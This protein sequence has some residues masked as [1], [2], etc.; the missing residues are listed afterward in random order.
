MLPFIRD[1]RLSKTYVKSG[2]KLSIRKECHERPPRIWYV[3]SFQL[4]A[5]GIAQRL[6][7]ENI[8]NFP[9]SDK[10]GSLLSSNLY[11][12]HVLET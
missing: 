2:T 5:F 12:K 11:P 7:L 9:E 3:G 4:F 6:L 1:R 10:A 8:L